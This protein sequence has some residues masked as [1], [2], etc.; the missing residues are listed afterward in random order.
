MQTQI[1]LATIDSLVTYHLLHEAGAS[2]ADVNSDKIVFVRS[3]GALIINGEHPF[4]GLF[5]DYYGE[6]QDEEPFI[7]PAIEAFAEQNGSA[8]LTIAPGRAVFTAVRNLISSD[9]SRDRRNS[10]HRSGNKFG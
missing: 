10:L 6:F 9:V 7:L 3:D 5:C 4:C 8:A 1:A 2:Q